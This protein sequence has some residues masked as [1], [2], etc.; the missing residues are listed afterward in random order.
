[1][2]LGTLFGSNV[3][4][5]SALAVAQTP[6]WNAWG[7]GWKPRAWSALKPSWPVRTSVNRQPDAGVPRIDSAR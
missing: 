2:A 6:N 3:Q 7:V 1:M 5:G 4:C